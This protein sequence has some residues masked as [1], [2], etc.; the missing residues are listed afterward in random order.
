MGR[1]VAFSLS[2]AERDVAKRLCEVL[3]KYDP[4]SRSNQ[5]PPRV[6]EIAGKNAI[7]VVYS[8]RYWHGFFTKL[9]GGLQQVRK[10]HP[11]VYNCSGLLP[12][13]G[14]FMS[15]DGSQ[16]RG[17][18]DAIHASSTSRVLIHQIRQILIDEGIWATI[19]KPK[20]QD[21]WTLCASAEF[22]ERFVGISKFHS[23]ERKFHKRHV[24]ETDEGFW[25]PIK[26]LELVPYSGPVF[27]LDVE[28]DHTYQAQGVAVHNSGFLGWIALEQN[29]PAPCRSIAPRNV[30]LTKE[31]I[32]N[33][34]FS[35][36]RGQMPEW[37]RD[38]SVT[39]SGMLLTSG[40]DH[41]K[42]LEIY[43]KKKQQR[44]RLEWV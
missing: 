3:L 11:S 12:L 16:P 27:N 15:G 31:E 42:K 19:S 20:S 38:P 35:P 14:A 4:P 22:I 21:I 5:K 25:A 43:S 23:V 37:L 13:A 30:M 40:N 44:N 10:I 17:Q 36:V 26:S 28:G 32:E 18:R 34:G 39:G 9:A 6:Q 24:V 7:R 1:G 2:S 8:S 41:L 33:A 29:H